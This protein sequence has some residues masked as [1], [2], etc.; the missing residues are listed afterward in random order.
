MNQDDFT[1]L[2][3]FGYS[4][5]IIIGIIVLMTIIF[6]VVKGMLAPSLITRIMNK[7]GISSKKEEP[8]HKEEEPGHK[9]EEPEHEEA[10]PKHEKKGGR[11]NWGGA[12]GKKKGTPGKIRR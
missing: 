9:E 7:M 11:T 3:A 12:R 4:I 8:G 10:E 6:Y 1:K 5:V 2:Q